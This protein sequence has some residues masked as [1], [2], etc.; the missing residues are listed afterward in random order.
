MLRIGVL[1]QEGLSA[2]EVLLLYFAGVVKVPPPLPA[3]LS[4]AL[5][6]PS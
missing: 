1:E 5:L 3:P 4:Q 6:A 2:A